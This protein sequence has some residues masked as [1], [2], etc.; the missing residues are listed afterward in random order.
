LVDTSHPSDICP[1]CIVGNECFPVGYMS[2]K[3]YCNATYELA[4]Q[5][6]AESDCTNNYECASNVC[7]DTKCVEPNL[8]EKMRTWITGQSNVECSYNSECAS[9]LCDSGKCVEP[10]IFERTANWLKKLFR[11]SPVAS[12]KGICYDSSS[13][14]KNQACGGT[15]CIMITS[16]EELPK[17]GSDTNCWV[18]AYRCC[19]EEL[20]GG[21]VET[22]PELS[23]PTFN[24]TAGCYGSSLNCKN[25]ACGGN[26]CVK[27]TTEDELTKYG[28]G[29][30]CWID[31]YR[32][33]YEVEGS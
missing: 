9:G 7:V 15:D 25:Q 2:G 26:D 21:P 3:F 16:Q 20:S 4:T 33:C 11:L 14:C 8:L 22:L 12:C 19:P 5:K 17:Y 28:S 27:I 18:G 32:C 29:A 31:A 13:N 23:T 6:I 1:G 24:C 10:N 30:N